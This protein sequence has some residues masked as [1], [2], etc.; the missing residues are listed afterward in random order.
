MGTASNDERMVMT[1]VHVFMGKDRQTGQEGIVAGRM[2]DMFYP[3]IA[4]DP[5]RLKRLRVIAQG[6]VHATGEEIRLIR[7]VRFEEVEVFKPEGQ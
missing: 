5:E 1:D 7:F 6:I 3:L 4:G 2:G